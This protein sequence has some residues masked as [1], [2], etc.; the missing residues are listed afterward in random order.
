MNMKEQGYTPYGY[1]H[2]KRDTGKREMDVGKRERILFK[3]LKKKGGETMRP[4]KIALLRERLPYR[5]F[6]NNTGK[7]TDTDDMQTRCQ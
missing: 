5:H 4:Y 6:L 3:A 2:R 1:G 7:G